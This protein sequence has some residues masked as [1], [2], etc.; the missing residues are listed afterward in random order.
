MARRSRRAASTRAASAE[1][2]LSR[3]QIEEKFRTYAPT[4]LPDDVVEKVI[5]RGRAGWRISARCAGLME[6]LRDAARGEA[7]P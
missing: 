5:A 1:N 4:R 2:P 3:A 6:L 7:Q